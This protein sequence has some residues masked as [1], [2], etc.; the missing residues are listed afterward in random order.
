MIAS[1]GSVLVIDS[2]VGIGRALAAAFLKTASLVLFNDGDT[3]TDVPDGY[4]VETGLPP[5]IDLVL[6][7][8][9]TESALGQVK[10][11]VRVR[12]E[13]WYTSGGLPDAL[14]APGPWG[15]LARP[16]V[17]GW[18]LSEVEAAELLAW[19]RTRCERGRTNVLPT[20]LRRPPEPSGYL[21]ALAA[22]CRGY[23]AVGAMAGAIETESDG[24]AAKALATLDWPTV[25]RQM[26]QIFDQLDVNALWDD[27]QTVGWW[28]ECL[29]G[30]RCPLSAEVIRVMLT[31]VGA[32]DA[33][34]L[35]IVQLVELLA[36]PDAVAVAVPMVA[37]VYSGFS[38]RP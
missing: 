34:P 27:V 14:D 29:S 37:A 32:R 35:K 33:R 11:Q 28:R 9:G 18:L 25:R 24:P 2:Q 15:I 17:A 13:A 5:S 16:M 12:T 38:R 20:V 4:L 7:H 21:P 23:L 31:D 26:T 10:R 36:S 8:Q 19:A 6:Y 1:G 3:T 22:L 30:S